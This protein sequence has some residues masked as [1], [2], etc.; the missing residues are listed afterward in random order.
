MV[1]DAKST[2]GYRKLI[3]WQKADQLAFDIYGVTKRY[4]R[5]E[6]FGITS[7]M[8]RCAVSVPANI[9]EGYARKGVKEEINFCNIAYGSLSELEYFLDFSLRLR[10]LSETEYNGLMVL[11]DET[12]LLLIGYIKSLK[13]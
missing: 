9:V 2:K 12:A 11:R 6:I 13:L 8:R 1:E 5:D 7:Q 4:P 10:Y 3:V